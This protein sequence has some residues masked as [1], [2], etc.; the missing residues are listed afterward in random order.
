MRDLNLVIEDR[1]MYVYTIYIHNV[2]KEREKERE[3]DRQT[4]RQT[5]RK[6]ER[7]R[8]IERE[9]DGYRQVEEER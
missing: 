4:D 7:K 5:E 1:L 6:R 3:R 9:R 8:V 2:Y